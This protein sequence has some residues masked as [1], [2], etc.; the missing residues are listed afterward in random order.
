MEILRYDK[1][2]AVPIEYAATIARGQLVGIDANGNAVLADAD[3]G[4]PI[5]AVGVALV[6]GVA[7][8]RGSFAMVCAVE[9][10]AASFTPG[11]RVYLSGTAGGFTATRPSS[12][13]NLV[14][15]VGV[16]YAATKIA[17]NV[18]QSQTVVQ[19][20]GNSTVAFG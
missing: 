1:D 11:A 19:A 15:P 7:G 9:D 6:S 5:P 14:Q 4:T 17:V 10:A 16:A 3:A 8:T 2:S 12:N 20:A 13:G 18:S